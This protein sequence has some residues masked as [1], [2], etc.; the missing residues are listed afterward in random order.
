MDDLLTWYDREFPSLSNNAQLGNAGQSNLWATGARNITAPIPR[1][2]GAPLNSQQSQQQEDLFTSSTR[3]ASSQGSFRFGNPPSGAQSSSQSQGTS[4]DEFPPLARN[5]NGDIGQE[6]GSNLMASFA[7]GAPPAA[8][9]AQTTQA[10]R[11][12]NGL[13]NALSANS[14]AAETVSPTAGELFFGT[15]KRRS[16]LTKDRL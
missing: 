2:Q 11:A 12:G 7:F 13:L 10:S 9:S 8:A 5:A 16:T 3:L 14:R 4:V 1:N 15:L 6:R